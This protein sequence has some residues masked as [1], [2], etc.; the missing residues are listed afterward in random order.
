MYGTRHIQRKLLDDDSGCLK[1]GNVI[2][3]QHS[4]TPITSISSWRRQPVK[5]QRCVR[6]RRRIAVAI[7]KQQVCT[8]APAPP[9]AAAA[10][11]SL[12]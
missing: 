8:I 2:N 5:V 12:A 7:P 1:L 3:W 4:M 11:G 9:P 10:T 6:L